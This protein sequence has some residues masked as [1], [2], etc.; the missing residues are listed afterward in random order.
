MAIFFALLCVQGCLLH[1]G[2]RHVVLW[3]FLV[4]AGPLVS[5]PAP[6]LFLAIW[7]PQV[8]PLERS[9]CTNC[10]R[11]GFFSRDSFQTGV[12]DWR[13]EPFFKCVYHNRKMLVTKM[14][15][16]MC[17]AQ[18]HGFWALPSCN[19]CAP[20]RALWAWP[21]CNFC[22]PYRALSAWPPCNFCVPYRAHWAWPPCNLCA[23]NRAL[24]AWPPCNFCAPYR[25]L[26]AWPPCNFCAPNR[27]LWA[28]PPCNCCAPNCA[29]WAWP[30]CS[31]IPQ[32][33]LFE[34]D[35]RAIFVP[36]IVLFDVDVPDLVLC[37]FQLCVG[38]RGVVTRSLPKI[39][40]ADAAQS[41]CDCFILVL[42]G[43]GFI[44]FVDSKT[45][46]SKLPSCNFCAAARAF[47]F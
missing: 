24:W 1:V 10:L 28:W 18:T 31:F 30:P 14:F 34:L 13:F 6:Y 11:C 35:L 19:C 9:L 46:R 16:S 36:H 29:L 32:I 27:A 40:S 21:P 23:P 37:C 44:S 45:S 26:W 7:S 25:A 42:K 2:G 3:H 47:V 39:L 38:H 12:T 8:M 41:R 22:A 5:V 4:F 17:T 33:V 15:L 20:F 43:R